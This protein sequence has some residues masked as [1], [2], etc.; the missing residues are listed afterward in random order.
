MKFIDLTGKIFNN[1]LFIKKLEKP[2]YEPNGR[3]KNRWQIQCLLCNKKGTTFAKGGPNVNG[4]SGGFNHYC[5]IRKAANIMKLFPCVLEVTRVSQGTYK[6][7]VKVKCEYCGKISIYRELVLT[8]QRRSKICKPGSC[9]LCYRFLTRNRKL[10]PHLKDLQIK[11]GKY[12]RYLIAKINSRKSSSKKAKIPFNITIM[13][14]DPV[15]SYCPIFPWLKIELNGP[16][17]S[18]P[19]LDRIIPNKGYIKGNVE[20]ISWRANTIKNN[21]SVKE[22][23]RLGDYAKERY[24]EFIIP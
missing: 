21:A 18:V 15:P 24:N 3:K 13:D 11:H 19:S 17:F 22:L 7:K 2:H 14:L 8:H 16:K 23:I 1:C 5:P 6:S 12:F 10:E 4:N 20:I 9:L